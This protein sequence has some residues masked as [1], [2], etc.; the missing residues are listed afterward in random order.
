MNGPFSLKRPL[1]DVAPGPPCSQSSTG[2]LAGFFWN[3][4]LMIFNFGYYLKILWYYY[5]SRKE[6]KKCIRVIL[7]IHC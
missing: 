1:K 4:K 3:L 2:A 6:P 5:L 7:F